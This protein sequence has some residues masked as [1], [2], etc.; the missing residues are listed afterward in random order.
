MENLEQEIQ[1]SVDEKKVPA[2]LLAA[3]NHDGKL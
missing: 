3:V 1:T 2:I